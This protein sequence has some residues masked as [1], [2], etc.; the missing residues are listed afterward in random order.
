[1]FHSERT[2]RAKRHVGSGT[3]DVTNRG[4]RHGQREIALL[5][6]GHHSWMPE[7]LSEDFHERLDIVVERF[8]R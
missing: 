8:P 5:Q 7:T 4:T 6:Q 3:A 1:M 2:C